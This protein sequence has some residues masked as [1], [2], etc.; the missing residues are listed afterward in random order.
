MLEP[1]VVGADFGLG[2]L[3]RSENTSSEESKNGRT[4][5]DDA[6]SGNEDGLAEHICVYLIENIVFLRNAASVDDP[7]NDDAVL[8]HAIE[9]NAGVQGGAF[10][11]GKSV[12]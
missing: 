1:L 8:L 10:D 4:E 3:D 12:I 7:A 6:S 9:D 2:F 11:V 5:A